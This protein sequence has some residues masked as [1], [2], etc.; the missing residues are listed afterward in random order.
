MEQFTLVI[1]GIIAV[2]STHIV[3]VNFRQG[4]IRASALLSLIV[5]GFFFFFPDITT[6]YLVKNI[7]IVFIGASFVGMAHSKILSNYI[8]LIISGFVF[9]LIYLNAS[10]FFAGY[11]GGLGTTACISVSVSIGLYL[12]SKT[13]RER[14]IRN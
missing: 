1:T 8:F 3:N 6:S 12:A 2:I 9:S 7:P 4:D 14:A 11:G 5:G 10:Q 13:I